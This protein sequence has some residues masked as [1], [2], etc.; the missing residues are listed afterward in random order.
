MPKHFLVTVKLF[1]RSVLVQHFWSRVQ[2][3]K[4]FC[5]NR[6]KQSTHWSVPELWADTPVTNSEQ[7]IF[8][9]IKKTQSITEPWQHIIVDK[10]IN[11]TSKIISKLRLG[12]AKSTRDSSS[13]VLSIFQ[14]LIHFNFLKLFKTTKGTT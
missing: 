6:Q 5:S 8:S 7:L 11:L 3:W 9:R 1:R 4:T 10:K 12:F 2:W 13:L 14:L